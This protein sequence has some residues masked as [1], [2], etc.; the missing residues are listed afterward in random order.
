[1]PNNRTGDEAPHAGAEH[2]AHAPDP[3]AELAAVTGGLAHEIRNPLSTLKVNLQLLR[4]DWRELA[5]TDPAVGDAVRRSLLRL[6][7]MVREVDRLSRILDD[8]LR[9]A[10]RHEFELRPHDLHGLLRELI[11]FVEPT[12]AAQ[13]VAVKLSLDAGATRV[14]IDVDRFKQAVLNLLLNALQAMPNGGT[15]TVRTR[16]VSEIPDSGGD[17]NSAGA[18]PRS[19]NSEELSSTGLNA[20]AVA[21]ADTGE[22]IAPD[23]RA[24]IFDPFYSTR[25]GGTGLGLATARRIVSD[26]GGTID[27]RSELGVGSTF[28]ITLPVRRPSKS[29]PRP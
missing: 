13:N 14:A 20:V 16:D 23:R 12:A 24:R 2:G 18:D 22:G 6:D 27:V 1:M 7:T 25:K 3:V 26:H 21:V 15:L 28:T 5:S 17:G 19:T 10:T 8:F 11:G 9:F 29:E 4:E